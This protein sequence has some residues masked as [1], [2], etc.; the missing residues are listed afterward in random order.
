MIKNPIFLFVSLIIV[1]V[2]VI[3]FYKV[4]TN[5]FLN[6]KQNQ[7]QASTS[8]PHQSD[9]AIN[10]YLKNCA[11]CHGQFGQGMGGHPSLQATRTAVVRCLHSGT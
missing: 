7:N 8:N 1:A 9:P 2:I 6:I 5:P 3:V 4:G 10:I 11:T